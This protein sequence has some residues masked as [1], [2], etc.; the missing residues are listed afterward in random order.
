MKNPQ[1][2]PFL[3]R[4][5]IIMVDSAGNQTSHEFR[6]AVVSEVQIYSR[7][8]EEQPRASKLFFK[9]CDLLLECEA[10]NITDNSFKVLIANLI[11][12]YCYYK[13]P[14]DDEIKVLTGLNILELDQAREALKGQECLFSVFRNGPISK[15]GKKAQR[16]KNPSQSEE[17]ELE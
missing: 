16:K 14:S 1:S 12:E 7:L 17:V 5:H 9:I 6:S 11:H 8:I 15:S 4:I 3:D 10:T 2:D 13:A